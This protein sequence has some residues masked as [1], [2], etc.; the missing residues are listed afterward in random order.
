[1]KVPAI[2]RND[3]CP[4]GSGK[5]YKKCCLIGEKPAA[6][7]NG[8]AGVVSAE[9]RQALQDRQFG[10]LEEVQA[11]VAIHT[12][13]RNERPL[14]EFHGLSP[15]QMYH[16]LHLPFTSPELV[17]FPAVLDTCPT[18]PILTLFE[19]L[20]A[21]IGEQGLKPT[22]KGNLPQ[23]FCREAALA[24]WGK[25]NYREKTQVGG[26]NREE[27]F[28]DLHVTRTVAELSGCIRM[29]IPAQSEHPFRFNVNIYSGRT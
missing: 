25:E 20:A 10:S 12:Q 7:N 8:A 13:E 2:G 22:T 23:K 28:F 21:A 19:R 9:L 14:D 4:C 17:Q 11:F 18:A 3:P 27:D 26:I 1:M 6:A 16:M 29:H 24:Y 5:K 15:G